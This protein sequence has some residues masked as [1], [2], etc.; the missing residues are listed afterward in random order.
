MSKG[1]NHKWA[2]V[3]KFGIWMDSLFGKKTNFVPESPAS[4]YKRNGV[5]G[6]EHD[7]ID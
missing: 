6:E 2:W 4:K 7:G 3:R 5:T 1:W